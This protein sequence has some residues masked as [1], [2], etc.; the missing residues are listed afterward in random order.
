MHESRNQIFVV[1]CVKVICLCVVVCCRSYFF[2]GPVPKKDTVSRSREGEKGVED[3][4]QPS[5]RS[6]MEE[7]VLEM[8]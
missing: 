6:R 4:E 1:W 8:Q 7:E 5:L 3:V 2:A